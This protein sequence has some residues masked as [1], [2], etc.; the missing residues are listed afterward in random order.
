MRISEMDRDE[1]LSV[2]GFMMQDAEQSRQEIRSRTETVL[3]MMRTTLDAYGP[4]PFDG[5]GKATIS[6][7]R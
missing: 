2:I 5:R 6:H 7:R 1:L 3:D 4:S